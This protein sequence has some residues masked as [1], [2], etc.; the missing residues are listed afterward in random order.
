MINQNQGIIVALGNFEIV[1]KRR[2]LKEL[3][4]YLHYSSY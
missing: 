1:L 4:P 2:K 3:F